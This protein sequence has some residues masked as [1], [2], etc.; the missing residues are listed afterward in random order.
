MRLTV[1]NAP[2]VARLP[3]DGRSVSPHLERSGAQPRT[4]YAVPNEHHVSRWLRR[5]DGRTAANSA[6]LPGA[7]AAANDFPI[8]VTSQC[9]SDATK[10]DRFDV[11]FTF[12]RGSTAADVAQ[13]DQRQHTTGGTPQ[14]RQAPRPQRSVDRQRCRIASR[15][16]TLTSADHRLVGY[17]TPCRR[18]KRRI[19]PRPR[20]T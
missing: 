16:W 2:E 6:T 18:E 8:G 13:P 1:K 19:A 10:I 20:A 3:R 11:R 15:Y 14:R 4:S 12:R 9:Q 17:R 7:R 5:I